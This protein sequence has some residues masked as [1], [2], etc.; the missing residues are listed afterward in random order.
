MIANKFILIPL[1]VLFYIILF[2]GAQEDNSIASEDITAEISDDTDEMDCSI[3]KDCY[4]CS[5][6]GG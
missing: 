1:S 5:F 3:F 4:N 2:T 6:T